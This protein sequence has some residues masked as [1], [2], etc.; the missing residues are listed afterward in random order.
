MA[1]KVVILAAGQG[2]RMFSGLPKVLHPL[3][4]K[5]MLGWVIEAAERLSPT[6]IYIVYGHGG[7][8]IRQHFA[9]A[10][11]N[12]VAQTEQLGTGHAVAQVLSHLD[13]EDRVVV[14]CGD[15]PLISAQTLTELT[16]SLA[17]NELNLVVAKLADPSGL[18]RIIRNQQGQITGI[19]EE[20]DA[21][22]AERS[23]DEIYAGILATSAANLL[24]WLP[25]LSNANA[26]QEYYLTQIV[27]FAI[28]ENC[29]I[30][31]VIA[32]AAEEIQG[33]NTRNQLIHLERYYQLNQAQQ[34]LA[35]GVTLMDPARFDL[36]GELNCGQDVLIDVNVILEGKVSIGNNCSI[37]ANVLLK[38]VQLADN[39]V[40]HANSVLESAII[41]DDCVIG[42][43]ARIRPGTR[44]AK[45]AK[46]GNFVEVKQAHI[47]PGSKVNH[48]SYIGDAALGSEVNIGAG[49][50]TC[51]YDGVNKHQTEIGDHAFIGSNTQLVAPVKVGAH[52]TIGAGSTITRDAPAGQ[53]SL[54]RAKQ[55]VIPNWQRPKKKDKE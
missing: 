55:Q 16:Q 26:Q 24:R 32:K 27:D 5:P 2:K 33:V 35:K 36:R 25:R 10:N 13:P 11:V 15:V 46:I 20:K 6:S 9:K 22:E 3:A 50:I 34:L 41:D 8:Q 44:L 51:N 49:T 38:N 31:G 21:T 19:V 17:Q 53:L 30:Q 37:G 7:E 29:R 18:G 14:L 48:L 42:P 43:F 54:S 45:G 12:W 52:A 39:V 40:I 4:G 28:A 1:L 23:I 47:G